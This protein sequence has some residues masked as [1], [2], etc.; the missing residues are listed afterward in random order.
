[1]GVEILIK[2]RPIPKYEHEG[3]IYIEG[4]KGSEY[5]IRLNNDLYY[6][7]KSYVV[8]VDGLCVIN[9]KPAGVDSPTFVLNGKESIIVKGWLKNN[10][11]ANKFE[12]SKVSKSYS[13]RVGEGKENVGVIGIM[14]F[15]EES[16]NYI[17]NA[18]RSSNNDI[19]AYSMV[20]SN[21]G[22][23]YGNET[24]FK[25]QET[26]FISEK[27][28]DGIHIIYYDDKKGLEKRGVVLDP[29]KNRPNA[30]PNYYTDNKFCRTP[31]KK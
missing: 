5:E 27:T 7:R 22:T 4:R 9:G 3:E 15:M 1:M 2:G 24:D 17:G 21:I 12:F 16:F 19:R 20:S 6:N 23:G 18:Y 29:M 11:V 13:N 26:H 25:T 31:V 14:E 10:Q 30:F 8:S 28:P